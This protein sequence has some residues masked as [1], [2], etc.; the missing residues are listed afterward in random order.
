[1]RWRMPSD[2]PTGGSS[3]MFV[4]GSPKR[5]GSEL[6]AKDAGMYKSKHYVN[7]IVYDIIAR[8]PSSFSLKYVEM[9]LE[10]FT[11]MEI[12]SCLRTT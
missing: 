10:L 6:S 8:P 3:A 12:L 9:E 2:L 4:R 11:C 7:L 1:M 5:S